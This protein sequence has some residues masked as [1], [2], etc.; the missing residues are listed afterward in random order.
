MKSTPK[1]LVIP[2]VIAVML[3]LGPLSMGGASGSSD[4]RDAAPATVDAPQASRTGTATRNTTGEGA[5]EGAR[6]ARSAAG[7]LVPKTPGMW[8]MSS[9]LVGVLLLGVGALVLLKRLRGGASPRGNQTLATL[10]Q[11]VRLS[12]KQALHAVEFDNRILLI[13]EGDKGLTLLERANLPDQAAD[14]A[15]VL[16]R[17]V[18]AVADD[19]DD[20]ATPRNLLIPRP[21][22]H[23][24]P[25]QPTKA[26]GEHTPAKAPTP[27]GKA[28]RARL[29]DFRALLEKAGR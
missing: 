24:K 29:G 18:D 12:A 19:E 27:A 28:G 1:W 13:G 2:P 23:T 25:A 20:G 6:G 16:G 5:E 14:E 22:Q 26:A 21:T 3:I 8:Q 10:R 4:A 7:S 11:T 17:A 15:E 9:A